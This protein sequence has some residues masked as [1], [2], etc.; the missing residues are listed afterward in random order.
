MVVGVPKEIKIGE[1]RVGLLPHH[2]KFIVDTLKVPVVVQR[3]AGS[4]I[5]I[6]DEAY[7]EAGATIVDTLEQV[8][9]R[10][11]TYSRCELS[12]GL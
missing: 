6:C 5:N 10:P 8:C 9:Q 12:R 3:G 1:H 4:G 2:V 11:T 7:H